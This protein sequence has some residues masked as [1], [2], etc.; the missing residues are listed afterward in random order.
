MADPGM[1]PRPGQAVFLDRD[2][3]VTVEGG[4][5]VTHPDQLRLLPGAAEAVARLTRAGWPVYLFTNQ[6]GV[7][8]GYLA[9]DMLADIHARLRLLLAEVGGE[10]AGV[11]AC[12]HSPEDNCACRKPKPGLLLRAARENA[13]DLTTCY[14]VGD[15]PRDLAAGCAA[16]CRTLLVLTGHTAHY[17]PGTFPEPHP[18]EVF[19]DVAAVADWFC[20]Q[21]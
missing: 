2:G 10:L 6:A 9:L 11:Y 12:P 4:D 16:G 3:V 8:R 17:D 13:L 14:V 20:A 19:A 5:Y 1:K 18:D 7:G 15:S 21:K